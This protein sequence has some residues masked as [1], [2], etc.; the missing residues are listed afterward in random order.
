MRICS[1]SVFFWAIVFCYHFTLTIS[2]SFLQEV[3]F[4][5]WMMRKGICIFPL[6][7]AIL[8]I[9]CMFL[10]YLKRCFLMSILQTALHRAALEGHIECVEKLLQYGANKFLKNVLKFI[11]SF[12]YLDILIWKSLREM[13]WLSFCLFK[14]YIVSH[15]LLKCNS[16]S[17]K[18]FLGY[19]M[20]NAHWHFEMGRKFHF[21]LI[22]FL[23]DSF[24][25]CKNKWQW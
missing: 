1:T 25:I 23:L 22:W 6:Q 10:V 11:H 9:G 17:S 14:L 16:L 8:F 24:W 3:I 13:Y 4:I 2:Y 20:G 15:I 12:C 18:Y 21:D 5:H 19:G 7:Y